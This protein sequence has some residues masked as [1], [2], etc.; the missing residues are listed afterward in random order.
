LFDFQEVDFSGCS[1]GDLFG[2]SILLHIAARCSG[3]VSVDVSWTNVG[4][5]GVEALA[6]NLTR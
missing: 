5:N 2:E 1:G 4:D 6:E 3:V